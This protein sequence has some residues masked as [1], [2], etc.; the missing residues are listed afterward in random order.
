V[1]FTETPIQRLLLDCLHQDR[2][3]LDGSAFTGLDEAGWD[4]LFELARA[5]RVRPLVFDRLSGGGFKGLAPAAAWK[6]L[7]HDCRQIALRALRQQAA[8]ADIVLALSTAG[9]PVIVLKGAHLRTT[10]YRSPALREM[11]DVDVLVHREQL[12]RAVDVIGSRGFAPSSPFSVEVEAALRHDLKALVGRGA[13]I[14][15]HWNIT[16]PGR[17]H[18]IDPAELW[19]HAVPFGPAGLGGLCLPPEDLVLHLCMHVAYQHQFEFGLRPFCDLAE[20][21]RHF[22]DRMDWDVLTRRAAA[23]HWTPGVSAALR[24]A[25]DLVGAEVPSSVLADLMPSGLDADILASARE[26]VFTTGTDVVALGT[27][28]SR[29]AGSESLGVRLRHAWRRVFL[30][31]AELASHYSVPADLSRLHFAGLHLRRVGELVTRRGPLVA[32]L[33]TRRDAEL[34]AVVERKNRL[35]AWLET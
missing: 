15:I 1:K 32:R 2:T 23:W 7:E 14:E 35:A 11:I 22:G 5:Q 6:G 33:L 18:S 25:R 26:Q 12:Q 3:R 13:V 10:V 24:L 27:K 28:I 17:P 20:T 31:R 21:I 16:S 9:I 4:E 30:P 8:V 29:L 19:R 34:N